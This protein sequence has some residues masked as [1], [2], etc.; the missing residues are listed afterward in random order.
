M[1]EDNSGRW[2]APPNKTKGRKHRNESNGNEE[3]NKKRQKSLEATGQLTS[4]TPRA[5]EN[6]GEFKRDE[7]KQN[8]K[9]RTNQRSP[10]STMR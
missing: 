5:V 3:S 9:A 4:A 7:T 8:D 2:K 6:D 1:P 10:M